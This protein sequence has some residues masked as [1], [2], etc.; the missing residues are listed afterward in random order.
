VSSLYLSKYPADGKRARFPH[1]GR[2][3]IHSYHADRPSTPPA[4]V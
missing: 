4:A 3:A 2:A 1:R